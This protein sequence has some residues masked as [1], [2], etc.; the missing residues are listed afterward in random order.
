MGRGRR[1]TVR[2]H[3]KTISTFEGTLQEKTSDD[4]LA[5]KEDHNKDMNELYV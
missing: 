4:E 1:N 3:C 2:H 5:H